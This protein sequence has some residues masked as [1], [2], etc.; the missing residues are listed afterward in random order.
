MSVMILILLILFK[1]KSEIQN[2]YTQ[3]K[4]NN[5]SLS[6]QWL[7]HQVEFYNQEGKDLFHL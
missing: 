5:H 6:K 4:L 2:L 7:L 1:L 3:N